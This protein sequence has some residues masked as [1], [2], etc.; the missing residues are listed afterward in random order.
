[1]SVGGATTHS[2]RQMLVHAMEAGA[3][4]PLYRR[5]DLDIELRK[6]GNHA[7][8]GEAFEKQLIVWRREEIVVDQPDFELQTNEGSGA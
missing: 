8:V 1:M 7:W 4:K 5:I 2:L 6:L 3:F